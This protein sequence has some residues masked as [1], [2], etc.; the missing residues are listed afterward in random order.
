MGR[1]KGSK[2]KKK[3][4]TIYTCSCCGKEYSS[5]LTNFPHNS[6]KAY[7]ANDHLMSICNSCVEQIFQDYVQQLGSEKLA[8]RRMCMLFNYYYKEKIYDAAVQSL[9]A[10]QTLMNKYIKLCNLVQ[11]KNKTFDDT[12]REE[13]SLLPIAMSAEEVEEKTGKQISPQTIEL[14]GEGLPPEDYVYLQ[15]Q[16]DDWTQRHEHNTK[17]QEELFKNLSFAQLNI[18]KA[19]KNGGRV[20]DAMK[21]FQD[22]LGAANLKPSQNVEDSVAETNTFGTLIKKWEDEEPIAEPAEEWKDVD[23]IVRYI[24]V[25]FLGHLCKMM[26]LKN[27][28]SKL[29]EEEMKK[30]SVT[31]P[32]YE[33]DDEA[34]FDAV[35][36]GDNNE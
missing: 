35:F 14:F 31:K 17:A 34:L 8:V 20:G 28:Y 12:L 18:L 6:Y 33:D 32:E 30:Y 27:R 23:G 2:N 13:N 10:T 5:R 19:Q 16:Y 7:E 4:N 3:D 21:A 9:S 15:M 25:F 26:G 1:P 11:Y 36:G 22:L 29:Y 24:T